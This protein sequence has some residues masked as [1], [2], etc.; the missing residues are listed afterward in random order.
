MQYTPISRKEQNNVPKWP[1]E[2]TESLSSTI[3]V[4]KTSWKRRENVDNQYDVCV[5]SFNIDTSTQKQIKYKVC[6]FMV[7]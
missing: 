1:K 6:L 4:V 5:L 3:D 7:S 2:I